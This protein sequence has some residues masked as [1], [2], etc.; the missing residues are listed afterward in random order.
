[1]DD[2]IKP[3]FHELRNLG[4]EPRTFQT[5][6]RHCPGTGL[7]FDYEITDGSRKGQ[8]VVLGFVIPANA[9]VWPEAT[10]HWIHISPID[11]VLEQQ[12]LANRGN[13]SG[14]VERYQDVDG[15]EWM[16]ISAPVKDF[17]DK[18][19]TP[20][21]KNAAAYIQQHIRRIWAAR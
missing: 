21:G 2:S 4:Y 11:S 1:M 13:S 5:A 3:L 18:I 6:M 8:N 20:D 15:R 9:G 12:V 19:D 17:W 16:A 14:S 7:S 10:P